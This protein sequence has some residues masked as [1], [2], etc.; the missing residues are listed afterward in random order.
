MVFRGGEYR[1]E[2]PSVG[3]GERFKILR[4]TGDGSKKGRDRNTEDSF[5]VE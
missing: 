3:G 2:Q 1:D 4:V 5:G